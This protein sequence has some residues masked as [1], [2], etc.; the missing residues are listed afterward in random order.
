MEF[1]S[2][3]YI[4]QVAKSGSVS[5]TAERLFVSQSTISKSIK[6][7]EEKLGVVLFSHVGNRLVPTYAGRQF[8]QHANEILLQKRDLER[9]MEILSGEAVGALS[10]AFPPLRISY[11]LPKVLPVFHQ[12][13][14]DVQIEI[15]EAASSQIDAMLLS[16][17]VDLAFYNLVDPSIGISYNILK[18]EEIVLIVSD[19]YHLLNELSVVDQ[20]ASKYPWVDLKQFE[21]ETFLLQSPSHRMGRLALQL[22][23]QNNFSPAKVMFID[24]ITA[25]ANLAAAGYG[26]C[27]ISEAHLNN[28]TVNRGYRCFSIGCPCLFSDFVFAYRQGIYL[29]KYAKSFAEIVERS[30]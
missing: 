23:E 18:H 7:T 28:I 1:Q 13:Y 19:S 9:E 10:V 15:Q 4:V 16:G 6:K 17:K 14:P 26:V 5:R 22:F 20:A 11:I 21:G 8:V 12:Q 30:V 24:N 2:M 29:S 3:E 25:A 27:I